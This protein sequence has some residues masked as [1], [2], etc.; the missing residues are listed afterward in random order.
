MLWTS[1]VIAESIPVQGVSPIHW[2]QSCSVF[3]AHG[4]TAWDGFLDRPVSACTPVCRACTLKTTSSFSQMV[5]FAKR[6][7]FKWHPELTSEASGEAGNRNNPFRMYVVTIFATVIW[8]VNQCKTPKP[9][10]VFMTL[11]WVTLCYDDGE[12]LWF[13]SRHVCNHR[14]IVNII[15]GHSL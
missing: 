7:F 12:R 10:V 3:M 15:S 14:A 8:R 11:E 13:Y 2:T 4:I 9:T 1:L 6:P 5:S